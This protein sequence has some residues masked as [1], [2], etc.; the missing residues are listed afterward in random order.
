MLS[1]MLILFGYITGWD[2]DPGRPVIGSLM[3]IA[4]LA[5]FILGPRAIKRITG[6]DPIDPPPIQ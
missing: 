1:A 6:K 2:A 5:V 3:I 4:G